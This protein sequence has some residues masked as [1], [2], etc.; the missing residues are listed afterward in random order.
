MYQINADSAFHMMKPSDTTWLYC[1]CS[2]IHCMASIA[3][4][5][6]EAALC[7][8][9]VSGALFDSSLIWVLSSVMLLG[10]LRKSLSAPRRNLRTEKEINGTVVGHLTLFTNRPIRAMKHRG[11]SNRQADMWASW[12]DKG[13]EAV[14]IVREEGRRGWSGCGVHMLV[15]VWRIRM[16]LLYVQIVLTPTCFYGKI[17]QKS[18][19]LCNV[20]VYLSQ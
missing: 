2:C 6:N 18:S 3:A 20:S 10:C 14:N 7:P 17:M 11:G 4:Y 12:E 9:D 15:F 19:Q 5:Y 1:D 13:S 8:Q 16:S